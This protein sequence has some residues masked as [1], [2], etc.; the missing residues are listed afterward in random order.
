MVNIITSLLLFMSTEWINTYALIYHNKYILICFNT[1]IWYKQACHIAKN[2]YGFS[3]A[4]LILEN[5][6]GISDVWR[7]CTNAW[8][9]SSLGENVE[10]P[11][12]SVTYLALNIKASIGKYFKKYFSIVC[13]QK[14][15]GFYETIFTLRLHMYKICVEFFI[16]DI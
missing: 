11:Y 5:I 10:L 16:K 3:F 1:S 2:L 8:V 4:F 9:A 13:C 15:Q 14:V 12:K 6:L 7:A